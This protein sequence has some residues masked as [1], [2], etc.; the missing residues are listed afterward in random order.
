MPD[1]GAPQLALNPGDVV[2]ALTPLGEGFYLWT[3]AAD[4]VMM[5]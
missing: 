3:P 4:K 2:Y 1:S 5:K